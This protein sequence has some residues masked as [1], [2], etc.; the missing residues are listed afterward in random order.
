MNW[1]LYTVYTYFYI[2][3]SSDPPS[4]N[5]TNL[6]KT[7]LSCTHSCSVKIPKLIPWH[8]Q[9]HTLSINP[10]I[11]RSSYIL[12][13]LHRWSQVYSYHPI[14]R[15]IRFNGDKTFLRY[16]NY[17]YFKP[18]YH[19]IHRTIRYTVRYIGHWSLVLHI[20][21]RYISG[22]SLWYFT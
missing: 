5:L 14:Y 21:A 1:K 2:T 16:Q 19:Q 13:G 11:S 22:I 20:Q 4:Y 3:T 12:T 7:T 10:A 6:L 18:M 15:V 8:I 17:A 9:E